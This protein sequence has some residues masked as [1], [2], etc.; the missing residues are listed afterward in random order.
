MKSG[1]NQEKVD[2]ENDFWV[3]PST[4][5]DVGIYQCCFFRIKNHEELNTPA[6]AYINIFFVVGGTCLY[7]EM[8]VQVG[9]VFLYGI[10]K[11]TISSFST[12]I[13]LFSINVSPMFLYKELGIMPSACNKIAIRFPKEHMFNKLGESILKAPK[14]QWVFIAETFFEDLIDKQ[15]DMKKDTSFDCVWYITKNINEKG[16]ANVD[17]CCNEFKISKRHLQRKFF[18][19]YGLNMRDYERIIRFSKAFCEV[20][21]GSLVEASLNCGYYDQ[22]HMCREFK[23]LAGQAPQ[24]VKNH[25]I[26][27][28]LKETIESFGDNEI[29]SKR[30]EK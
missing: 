2:Y 29:I 27:N 13:E 12:N 16:Y 25:A 17:A 15:R 6:S 20:G 4:K 1:L 11:N 10:S 24:M 26:Y 7:N 8:D 5:S 22:S 28:S 14:N 23:E 30:K 9:D 21:E 19:F 3:V 18:Q